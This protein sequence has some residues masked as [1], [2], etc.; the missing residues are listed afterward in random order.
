MILLSVEDALEESLDVLDERYSSIS[1]ILERPLFFDS[2]EVRRVV[3]DI[4]E[5]RDAIIRVA[6]SLSN[7][8]SSKDKEEMYLEEKEKD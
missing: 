2:P 7:N 1:E 5:C 8:V 4:G 6:S 3:S